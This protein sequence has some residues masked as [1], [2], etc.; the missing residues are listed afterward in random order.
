MHQIQ[1]IALFSFII[2]ISACGGGGGSD[3][4]SPDSTPNANFTVQGGAG[5]AAVNAY[6]FSEQIYDYATFAVA[7]VQ[8]RNP[9]IADGV[10]YCGPEGGLQTTLSDNDSS[11]NVSSG[12][13]IVANLSGCELLFGIASGMVVID[14]T[15]YSDSLVELSVDASDL[16]VKHY[17][18]AQD[19][20]LTGRVDVSYEYT[21]L[22]ATI[23]AKA[24]Q[25][26]TMYYEGD[27][28]FESS[29]ISVKRNEN[30]EIP[31]YTFEMQGYIKDRL[32]NTEY[33][34][35]SIVPWK[36]YLKEYPYEGQMQVSTS[37]TDIAR[38]QVVN[39]PSSRDSVSKSDADTGNIERWSNVASSILWNAEGTFASGAR[40]NTENA[41]YR[42]S[43][44]ADSPMNNS[45]QNP[46]LFSVLSRDGFSALDPED[47]HLRT[48][49]SSAL[50]I[51]LAYE[52]RG[53]TLILT[54]TKPLQAY[55][56]YSLE[57][58]AVIGRNGDYLNVAENISTLSTSNEVVPIYKHSSKIYRD[59]DYPTLDASATEFNAQTNTEFTFEWR[60]ISNT[61]LT[62]GDANSSTTS[63]QVP[64]GSNQNIIIENAIKRENGKTITS[65]HEFAYV[66][67]QT[68]HFTLHLQSAPDRYWGKYLV[69]GDAL[70]A[71]LEN[72]GRSLNIYID[73]EGDRLSKTF[74][75]TM[76]EG[77]LITI[78]EYTEQ[79]DGRGNGG[80][81][82]LS[83]PQ[84][85]FC[86]SD[87]LHIEILE[88][89][90]ADNGIDLSK[91]AMNIFKY[92]GDGVLVAPSYPSTLVGTVRVNSSIPVNDVNWERE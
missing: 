35:R 10:S 45:S 61:G 72:N 16:V 90:T 60:E 28:S 23:S 11:G 41:F 39:V 9:R 64:Q 33:T 22:N 20:K 88:M 1:K 37:A 70:V 29:N 47:F 4:P 5:I 91:L 17:R 38:L 31:S 92:C 43:N 6:I 49:V 75:L 42:V 34:L 52:I 73:S 15:A 55:I 85:S 50:D 12:D 68:N 25:T 86:Q 32:L 18:D 21:T 69:Q 83:L 80:Y 71:K 66:P 76:L 56:E 27:V 44:L 13:S 36:G 62:F 57:D 26:L 7:Y 82:Y 58:V 74:E 63:I 81:E 24:A 30:L 3:S 40:I 78:G 8:L 48:E 89:E 65:V 67:A 59:G 84:P 14:V 46:T 53:A 19:V 87:D 54:P 79:F 77:D 51:P 2:L